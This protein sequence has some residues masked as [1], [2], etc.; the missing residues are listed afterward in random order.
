M[1][2]DASL[3][4]ILAP[5]SGALAR[6][7]IQVLWR[8]LVV[9]AGLVSRRSPRIISPVLAAVRASRRSYGGIVDAHRVFAGF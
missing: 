1:S 7:E 8:V 3:I 5:V 6:Q 9:L 4:G 2:G